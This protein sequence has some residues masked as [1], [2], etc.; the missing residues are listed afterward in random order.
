M[1]GDCDCGVERV[2]D[3]QK[4]GKCGTDVSVAKCPECGAAFRNTFPSECDC[5]ADY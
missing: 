1:A 2:P 5:W 3:T 4:C